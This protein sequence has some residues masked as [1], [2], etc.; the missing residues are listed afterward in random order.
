MGVSSDAALRRSFWAALAIVGLS[1]SLARA[2]GGRLA[3]TIVDSATGQPVACQVYLKNA[4]GVPQRAKRLPFYRDH[5]VCDGKLTLDLPRGQYTFEVERGPEYAPASGHFTIEDFADDDHRLELRRVV[6]L[7]A[8]GWWSGDLHIHRDLKDLERLA[9][10]ADLHVAP[11]ITWWNEKNAWARREPPEETVR[12]FGEDLV[13][14]LLAGE[15]ERGGGALLY[16]GLKRPLAISDAEREFP[17]SLE[18]ARQARAEGVRWID[19]EKPFWWDFPVWVAAEAIDSVGLVHNHLHRD[20]VLDN[21]AWGR[22]RDRRRFSGLAGNANYTQ[23][24]YY[25]LL[26]A[27]IRLPPSA[28]SASGVLPNPVGYNR[29]YVFIPGEF[30]AQAWWDGFRAG[31]VM[32][33]NGPLLRARVADER[34][35]HVFTGFAGQTLH[36]QLELDLATRDPGGYL[37]V[38]RDGTVVHSVPLDEWAKQAILPR[39]EFR[40]SGWFLARV[41][42]ESDRT[43]RLGSTGPFY[44]EIDN[45]P[46]ISRASAQFFLD[47]VNERIAMLGELLTDLTQRDEVLADHV[48][49]REFWQA[50]VEAA[51]AP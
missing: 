1:G 35:G 20:E 43:V 4:A 34:P 49:A 41:M 38:V 6:D 51:T 17:G 18:F 12:Q 31:R 45:R 7:T 8:E 9:R 39:F 13:S 47:W 11:V 26:E 37:E 50:R 21:E 23:A 42:H 24:I 33:T 27:G 25:H 48:Q 2:S 14:D 16:F 19:A 30:S 40:E 32:V 46:R 29:V 36:L 44:V 5:F 28:G 10:A 3:L 22:P 15:D